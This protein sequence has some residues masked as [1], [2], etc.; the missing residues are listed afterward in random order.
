M[1]GFILVMCFRFVFSPFSL[2]REPRQAL[3]SSLSLSDMMAQGRNLRFISW[4]LKGVNQTIKRNKV[5]VT[6]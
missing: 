2:A 5:I 3:E 4:N 1:Y 6:R